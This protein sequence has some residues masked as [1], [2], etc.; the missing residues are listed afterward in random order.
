M[1]D[2]GCAALVLAVR[3]GDNKR[4]ELLLANHVDVNAVNN[5]GTNALIEAVCNGLWI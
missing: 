1:E 5:S 4:V 2:K 3:K